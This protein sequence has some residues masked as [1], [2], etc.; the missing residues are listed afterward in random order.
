MV[1]EQEIER[2]KFLKLMIERNSTKE[3]EGGSDGNKE[4]NQKENY[5]SESY[6]DCFS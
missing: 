1:T 2:V 4:E 5:D 6:Y 3:K